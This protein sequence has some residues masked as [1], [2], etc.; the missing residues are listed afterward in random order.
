[1]KNMTDNLRVRA[2]AKI[3]LFLDVTGRRADGYHLLNTVMQT[4]GLCDDLTFSVKE[5]AGGRDTLI[6]TDAEG[7][8]RFEGIETDER[9][10][11]L[12]A[13]AALRESCADRF[14]AGI[15]FDIRLEKRIPSGAGLG[16]GSADCAAALLAVDR[17]LGLGLTDDVLRET[18]L[19]LGADVPFCL[20]GG[21]MRA[22]GIGEILTPLAEMP[23]CTIVI[24]K[25]AGSAST[26]EIYGALDAMKEPAHPSWDD[27]LASLNA[28]GGSSDRLLRIGEQLDE[29]ANILESVTAPLV[30]AVRELTG[31]LRANGA[32]GARMTG[33]GSAVYGLFAEEGTAQAAVRTIRE[34]GIAESIQTTGPVSARHI[35]GERFF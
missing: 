18:A 2:Y 15:R 9:N 5:G 28:G 3:N 23:D 7:L 32:C 20:F 13:V 12:R 35:A 10:L 22:E 17:M 30:P 31:L 19:S 6:L 26:K 8:G 25:P 16:G 1:M 21:T 24:A 27:F 4:I 33:S 14:P 11:V 34:T 29:R